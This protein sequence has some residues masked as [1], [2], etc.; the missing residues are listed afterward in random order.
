MSWN[1]LKLTGPGKTLGRGDPIDQYLADHNL[2]RQ[3]IIKG[4]C[5]L[6]RVIA[7]Q[8]YDTQNLHQEVREDCVR[9]MMDKRRLF[10]R[11]I[12]GN[13]NDYLLKLEKPKTRGT[14]I[15]LR[16]L[17]LMYGR[18]AIVHEPMKLGTPVTFSDNYKENFSVFIDRYGHFDAVYPMEHI[19]EAAICQSITF[20][21][22]YQMCFRL[23][24]VSLAAEKML[25]P[26]TFREGTSLELSRNGTVV[27]LFCRNGRSFDLDSPELTNCLMND[28]EL[29]DFHNRERWQEYL[30]RFGRGP[31]SCTLRYMD[32]NIAP[33]SYSV[34]KSLSPDSYRNVELTSYLVMKKEAVR[35]Q[36][37]IGDYDF[38]VGAHCLVELDQRPGHMKK[39]Y[40][41]K[42][43][44]S[45]HTFSVYVE[46]MCKELLVPAKSV[47]PLPPGQ[48]RP[49]QL[50][51]LQR[52]KLPRF[53]IICDNNGNNRKLDTILNPAR[54]Q[55]QVMTSGNRMPQ[56]FFQSPDLYLDPTMVQQGHIFFLISSPPYFKPPAVDPNR[57]VLLP[58]PPQPPF[59]VVQPITIY[60]YVSPHGGPSEMCDF[61][62]W[63]ETDRSA[64]T[65]EEITDTN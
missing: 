53:N 41:Q 38:K 44:W 48:F 11:N 20:T 23:P 30:M 65:I 8:M 5:S 9:F 40:I 29:C 21:M 1:H 58:S 34:A 63:S 39:C 51:F 14:M 61:P 2:Y 32:E 17:C 24:D 57:R 6:F 43:D 33:F 10:R 36:L 19:E 13:F 50:S 27:R 22:L 12:K 25:N 49:W 45:T 4:G 60:S 37:Y 54:G 52:M 64:L 26:G 46:E 56:L 28:K 31:L 3:L 59:M 18:N 35:F 55:N 42:I 15:E 62:S 47:H 7:E 16:A